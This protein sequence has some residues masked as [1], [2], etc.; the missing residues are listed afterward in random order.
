LKVDA[1]CNCAVGFV[2]LYRV[3]HYLK[4]NLVVNAPVCVKGLHGHLAHANTYM[5]VLEFDTLTELD[6]ELL[7]MVFDALGLL[8]HLLKIQQDRLVL[9][10]PSRKLRLLQVG[11]VHGV[12]PHTAQV[13]LVACEDCVGPASHVLGFAI[14]KLDLV[15]Q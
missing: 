14:H 1:Y 5:Q 8:R 9:H 7:D 10:V 13:V 12:A 4:K 11:N 15:W 2:E 6:H 3:A